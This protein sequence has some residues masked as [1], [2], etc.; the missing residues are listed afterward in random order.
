MTDAKDIAARIVVDFIGQTLS[1]NQDVDDWLQARISQALTQYTAAQL[2]EHE[3]KCVREHAHAER[4]I[5]WLKNDN[6]P[7]LTAFTEGPDRQ[8]GYAVEEYAEAKAKE[9]L[10]AKFKLRMVLQRTTDLTTAFDDG[11]EEAA[12]VIEMNCQCSDQT[13]MPDPENRHQCPEA[14]EIRA[15]KSQPSS[16]SPAKG[17]T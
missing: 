1:S 9:A 8:V 13:Y 6:R 16:T 14:I 15:L 10:E 2:S 7:A 4:L 12:K 5:E 3:I 17:K 11:L